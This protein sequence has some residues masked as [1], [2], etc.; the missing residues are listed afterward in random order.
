ME[1][2]AKASVWEWVAAAIGAALVIAVIG[3]MAYQAIAARADLYPRISVSVD[4]I[5]GYGDGY[6]VEFR[7]ENT[8]SATVA[9]LLVKGRISSDTGVVEESEVTIDFVP[10][11]SRQRGGLL[12]TEDPRAYRL[13]VR[14][15]G[16]DRP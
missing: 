13:E 2:H 9:G 1:Q 4:T 12:F 3:F 8:G 5:I 6:I 10:P 15:A 11:K 16:Y 7:A 14:P